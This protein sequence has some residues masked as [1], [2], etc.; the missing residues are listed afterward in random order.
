M[1]PKPKNVSAPFLC[2]WV[3]NEQ[4][5]NGVKGNERYRENKIRVKLIG[6][7]KSGFQT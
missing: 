5:R 6:I 2:F 4:H 7:V 3:K 1:A